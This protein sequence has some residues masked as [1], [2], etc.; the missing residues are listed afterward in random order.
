MTANQP[1]YYAVSSYSEGFYSPYSQV[2]CG[3]P[4]IAPELVQKNF[5][6]E[7]PHVLRLVF[8]EAMSDDVGIPSNYT[9][10]GNIGSPS[11][12]LIEG[13]RTSVILT[14]DSPFQSGGYYQLLLGAIHDNQGTLIGSAGP[15]ALP[16]PI[17]PRSAPYLAQGFLQGLELTLEFSQP[18]DPDSTALLDRYSITYGQSGVV[19]ITSVQP[20]T[21]NNHYVK[22]NISSQ[23]PMGALGHVYTV[24]VNN[25][26]SLDGVLIDPAHSSIS[27]ARTFDRLETVFAYPN[28]YRAGDVVDGEQCVMIANLTPQAKVW[29]YNISGELVKKLESDNT[30]GGVKW[31]LDNENGD[32][33]ANGIYI[34]YVEGEDDSFTGKVAIMR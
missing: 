17:F 7:N 32:A 26:Y 29:I 3:I 24:A 6:L 18:M 12:A 20:D 19:I 22:L 31:L 1:Y 21:L 8:S 10:T 11:T 25:L 5:I 16:A 27:V 2:V 23:T 30:F 34:Y 14:F 15:F 28:P 33:V 9:V 4:N 13:S